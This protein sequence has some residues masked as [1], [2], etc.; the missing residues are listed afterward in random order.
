MKSG[1]VKRA[2]RQLGALGGE[3]RHVDSVVSYWRTSFQAAPGGD[4]SFLT[5]IYADG[6]ASLSAKRVGAGDGEY[7]WGISYGRS[8]FAAENDL[9]VALVDCVS[10]VLKGQTRIRQAKGLLRYSFSCELYRDGEWHTIGA[11]DAFRF[12]GFE[13]PPA[14]QRVTEYASPPLVTP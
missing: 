9:L 8:S 3:T 11:H 1:P 2:L 5:N 6:G 7:F 13:F 4:Y 10:S 12:G 14:R